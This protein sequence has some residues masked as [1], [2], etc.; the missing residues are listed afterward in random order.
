M[1][2]KL[3]GAQNRANSTSSWETFKYKIRWLKSFWL[4]VET[5]QKT[6]AHSWSLF[7]YSRKLSSPKLFET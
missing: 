3:P 2:V 5:L 7:T 4:L 1:V 6:S